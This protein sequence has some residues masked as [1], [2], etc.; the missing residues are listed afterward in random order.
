[1]WIFTSSPGFDYADVWIIT[2]IVVWLNWLAKAQ[3]FVSTRIPNG[4]VI[5]SFFFAIISVSVSNIKRKWMHDKYCLHQLNCEEILLAHFHFIFLWRG[6][7][8]NRCRDSLRF[9]E[10]KDDLAISHL[11]EECF[12]GFPIWTTKKRSLM[13]SRPFGLETELMILIDWVWISQFTIHLFKDILPTSHHIKRPTN[14]N[15]GVNVEESEMNVQ[16]LN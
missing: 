6:W 8:D 3:F 12:S 15:V 7:V 4:I 1:M 11:S 10:V 14:N 16:R 13:L 5:Q 2:I 9:A